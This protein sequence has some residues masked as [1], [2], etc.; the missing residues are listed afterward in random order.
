METKQ[1]FFDPKMPRF[2]DDRFYKGDQS[3]I[4]AIPEG[5]RVLGMEIWA[6]TEKKWYQFRDGVTDGDLIESPRM[7][8]GIYDSDGNGIVNNAEAL[9]TIVTNDTVTDI[10]AGKS[11]YVISDPSNVLSV[12][13]SDNLDP[14][15]KAQG[16]AKT[17]IPGN[18]GTGTVIFDGIVHDFDTQGWITGDDLFYDTNGDFINAKPI[19]GDDTRIGSVLIGGLADGLIAVDYRDVSGDDSG[20]G[21]GPAVENRYAT[22][23]PMFNNQI[24]QNSGGFQYVDDASADP[25]VDSGF[26]YYEYLGTTAGDLTDY[27]LVSATFVLTDG[28]GTTANGT[29]VDL[30]GNLVGDTVLEIPNAGSFTIKEPSAGDDG[31]RRRIKLN[32]AEILFEFIKTGELYAPIGF[33]RSGVAVSALGG[34]YMYAQDLAGG[35]KV[36]GI[37]V[38]ADG[39]ILVGDPGKAGRAVKVY[40]DADYSALWNAMLIAEKNRVIPDIE[41]ILANAGGAVHDYKIWYVD[42]DDGLD[43][44]DG[45]YDTPL[46]G[47]Q[48]AMD[49]RVLDSVAKGEIR[50]LT[51]GTIGTV[52]IPALANKVTSI[53][54]NEGKFAKGAV[55]NVV[56]HEWLILANHTFTLNPTQTISFPPMQIDMYNCLCLYGTEGGTVDQDFLII[57]AYQGSEIN[58]Q[59]ANTSEANF[60]IFGASKFVVQAINVFI[61]KVLLEHSGHLSLGSFE[62]T[63]EKLNIQGGSIFLPAGATL[64]ITDRFDDAGTKFYGGGTLNVTGVHSKQTGEFLEEPNRNVLFKQ[65]AG[66]KGKTIVFTATPTFDLNDGNVQKMIITA[67]VT[68]LTISNKVNAGSYRIF[69]TQNAT[70]GYTIPVPGAS[71]GTKTDNAADLITAA[72]DVNIIDITVDPD[73]TT[74]YS[75]ETITA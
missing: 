40:Y 60:Q 61:Y 45:L 6:Y 66:V 43:T 9:A 74:F 37:S 2:L 33:E 51:G 16:L 55:Y 41:W 58:F 7:D 22:L 32:P 11:I 75:V 39:S 69:L 13:V 5:A 62:C 34:I 68:S 26:A 70:G 17:I 53:I 56:D 67:N 63:F 46:K 48:K 64:T 14:L 8:K 18:G 57:S 42:L 31:N 71:F 4:L 30:G 38:G 1:G 36:G 28:S 23:T 50:I 29:A 12:G 3:D 25:L 73:G 15:K 52:N 47:V 19:T 10:P 59:A 35:G 49:L 24:D 44:N 65:Q 21:G 72:N 27:N 20:G 54:V